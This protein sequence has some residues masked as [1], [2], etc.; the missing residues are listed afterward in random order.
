MIKDRL[1]KRKK[2]IKQ[3]EKLISNEENVYFI[4]Y[5]CESFFDLPNGQSPRITSIAVKH[6]RTGQVKSFSIHMIAEI[7]GIAPEKITEDRYREI[8][9]QMLDEFF[10]FIG[11]NMHCYWV[12]WNMRNV[13]YGFH[14]LEHRYRV[15]K[16]EPKFIQDT[17]KFDLSELLSHYYGSEYI[18][19]PTLES[20]VDLNNITKLDFLSGKNEA[21]AFEAVEYVKLHR[22]TLRKVEILNN[23][24]DKFA[25]KNLKTNA[26]VRNQYGLDPNSLLEYLRSSWW[27]SALIFVLGFLSSSIFS[28]II[29]NI[30]NQK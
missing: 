24:L 28:T 27:G 26:T 7:K 15:L 8:E 22:S 14:A 3:I 12:H 16:G 25:S 2:A 10:C 6:K 23:I 1:D 4:H 19:D 5:S 18:E 29:S 30:L 11:D 9:T 13:N 17:S 21:K 20:L